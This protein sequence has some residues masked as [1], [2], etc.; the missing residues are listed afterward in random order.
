MIGGIYFIKDERLSAGIFA[1]FYW[2]SL[3]VPKIWEEL[4]N[5]LADKVVKKLESLKNQE[6]RRIT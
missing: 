3:I 6:F 2:G 4:A 1:A 5:E